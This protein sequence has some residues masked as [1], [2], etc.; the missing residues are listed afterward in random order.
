MRGSRLRV[1]GVELALAACLATGA[2]ASCGA[3]TEL[4]GGLA[5][6]DP[7]TDARQEPPPDVRDAGFPDVPLINPCPDAAATLI[8]VV[9][10]DVSGA[11]DTLFS[12]DPSTYAFTAIGVV[13]CP[14]ASSGSLNS[15]AV[16]RKGVAYVSY[17]SGALYRVS[18]RTAECT[19]TTFDPGG[20]GNHHYG[21]GFV[22]DTGDGGVE[23]GTDGETL[24]VSVQLN[25]GGDVLYSIDTTTFA[26]TRV[27]PFEPKIRSAEL[28]GTGGGLLYTF[29]SSPSGG[30]RIDRIDDTTAKVLA[31]YPLPGVDKGSA[32]AFGYWG[33]DFFT[34]TSS[35]TTTVVHR[36]DPVMKIV[37]KVTTAPIGE[38]IVGAGVSTCAPHT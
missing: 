7:S 19:A 34:F 15:M 27:G 10:V 25:T 5:G 33:G 13:S 23:G 35:G 4:P 30:S 11:T 22:A 21:M 2:A 3:R 18:T 12:F 6:E 26:L 28:T 31:E 32:W 8:Y 20:E 37:E 29:S 17:Q 1:F 16:D 24:F 36:F 14:G 38:N 9:A